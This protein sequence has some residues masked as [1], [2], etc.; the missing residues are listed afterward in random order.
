LTESADFIVKPD[1]SNPS[2]GQ[3]YAQ[4]IRD[5]V[6]TS[7]LDFEEGGVDESVLDEL[8]TVGVIPK[9]TSPEHK[10]SFVLNS[11]ACLL[12]YFAFSM[13]KEGSRE[14][15]HCHEAWLAGRSHCS[16][17]SDKAENGRGHPQYMSVST[18][19]WWASHSLPLAR[20]HHSSCDLTF[21]HQC[22]YYLVYFIVDANYI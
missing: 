19:L 21:S 16:A 1:M 22:I 17:T 20:T 8:S 6:E 11:T 13:A 12:L 15:C 9:F 5:V 7:R 18:F 2:V 4:I 10:Y 3:V 14:C